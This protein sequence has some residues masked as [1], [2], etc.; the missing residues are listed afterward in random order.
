V[1]S[2]NPVRADLSGVYEYQVIDGGLHA[3]ITGYLGT[4]AVVDIPSV[5]DTHPVTS[6]GDSSF[7]DQGSITAVTIP[8]GVVNIG[9]SAFYQCTGLRSIVIPDS[10]TAI[11]DSAFYGDGVLESVDMNPTSSLATIGPSAFD[12]CVSLPSFTFTA[13]VATVGSQAFYH[14]SSL[15]TVDIPDNLVTIGEGAF[16]YCSALTGFTVDD[17]NMNYAAVGGVLYDKSMTVLVQYP[18]VRSG[19]PTILDGTTNI[20]YRAF[21]HSG[22][23]TSITI[24]AS[25]ISIGGE[26]F[27]NCTALTHMNFNGAKPS[28]GAGWISTHGAGLKIY[29]YF[30]AGF[31][32][33]LWQGIPTGCISD[34]EM[35]T[36]IGTTSPAEGTWER[37]GTVSIT[38]IAPDPGEGRYVFDGWTGTGD[39]GYTGKDNPAS[40]T[41]NGPISQTA[42]WT[43]QYKL[44]ISAGVGTTSPG[45]GEHWYEAGSSV[46]IE[47]DQTSVATGERYVFAGWSGSG[48]GSFSGSDDSTDVIMNGPITETASWTHQYQL[49]FAVSPSGTGST[50]PSGSGIWVNAGTLSITATPT[51][52]NYFGSW[53]GS[54]GITFDAQS[55]STTAVVN[56][57]GTVTANMLPIIGITITSSPVGS[58]YIMVDGAAYSA[59]HTFNWTMNSVHSLS[60]MSTVSVRAGERYTFS[61]WSDGGGQVHDYTVVT[62][63]DVV[64]ALFVHEYQLTMSSNFGTTN[65]GAGSTWHDAGSSV[66]INASLPSSGVG[67]RFVW[68]GWVGIGPG[69]YSGTT[70]QRSITMN[71]PIAETASW[72]HQYQVTMATDIGT[73]APSSGT[74]WQDA[75]TPFSITA[76]QPREALGERYLFKGWTGTGVGNYTGSTNPVTVTVNGPVTETASW[77]HQYR[78]TLSANL[79][80]TTPVAGSYWHD[81]S[82]AVSISAAAMAT[83]AGE[84]TSFIGWAGTGSGSYSG[85]TNSVT[86]TMNG[87]MTEKA[88]WTLQY[89]L[90]LTASIGTTTP[91]LGST[92]HDALASV[93]MTATPPPAPAGQGYAFDFWTGTGPGSYTGA[94][95]PVTLTMNGPITEDAAWELMDLPIAPTGLMAIAGDGH[96]TLNWTGPVNSNVDHYLVYQDGVEVKAVSTIG[97]RISGLTNGQTYSFTVKAHNLAGIGPGSSFVLVTPAEALLKLDISSPEAWSY[98]NSGNVV[99]RWT[100]SAMTSIVVRT[101]VRSDLTAWTTVTGS[102]STMSGLAQGTRTLYVRVTDA[103]S[104][105]NTS[106]VTIIVDPTA[107]ILAITS[108]GSASYINSSNIMVGWTVVDDVSGPARTE[109]SVDGSVWTTVAGSSSSISMQDGPRKVYVRA[110]DHA[111]ND[112]TALVS[113]IVDTM[114]PTI[115]SKMPTGSKESTRSTVDLTFSEAMDPSSTTI[116]LGVDGSLVWNGLDATFMPSAALKGNTSYTATVNGK[117]LAGNPISESWTFS[118][119]RVGKISGMVHGHD[120]KALANAMVRLVGHSVA[121]QTGMGRFILAASAG[122]GMLQTTTSDGNGSYAFHDV[123][124]GE[125]VLEVEEPGYATQSTAVIMTAQDVD[126]GGLT[127]DPRVDLRTWRDGNVL[128][129]AVGLLIAAILV[130]V[131]VIRRRPAVDSEAGGREKK[132]E[133]SSKKKR[134]EKR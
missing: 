34:L 1:L 130:L 106:S 58:G 111:G 7:S 62:A 69:N 117:D 37:N 39:G 27:S 38:A 109:V 93:N 35:D 23:M 33:P 42:H 84:R 57:P 76:G 90:T 63:A 77:A 12:S 66:S 115:S 31:T 75:G 15:S 55:S 124:I 98:N 72:M 54:A 22:S 127:V 43:L 47:G 11:G 59:P 24:P 99:L 26:G 56:A 10:V 32:T 100:A 107:P 131:I 116:S 71:G 29:Y 122:L 3:E 85:T 65:P 114:P 95:N 96:V 126:N 28:F 50:T 44:T 113:F 9:S 119:A 110:T 132:G 123:A 8:D 13:E 80:T 18:L 128:I 101:E 17:G 51:G 104:R 30:G 5:L 74:S 94:T 86:L 53:S 61:S 78:L 4:D 64:T 46:T 16:S 20:G 45:A 87:P 2:S 49:T 68:L 14:C 82:S 97:T 89:Q 121:A 40:I 108:P 73:T 41:M 125:Y 52:A 48:A 36:N 133:A 102:S 83:S 112:R 21:F 19:I 79:G 25:V 60:A 91:A 129:M 88:A 103:D 120:G 92:W 67:E 81:A 134:S 118:T 105:V 70:G 6:I